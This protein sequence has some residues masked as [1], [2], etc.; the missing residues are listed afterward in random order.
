MVFLGLGGLIL[1]RL[2]LQFVLLKQI[3]SPSAI[4]I[5]AVGLTIAAAVTL[6][7]SQWKNFI[8]GGVLA[9]VSLLALAI[10]C[11]IPAASGRAVSV[12]R[13]PGQSI[14]PPPSMA[15]QPAPA[16]QTVTI[17][18]IQTAQGFP[19][20]ARG[21]KLIPSTNSIKVAPPLEVNTPEWYGLAHTEKIGGTGGVAYTFLD[22][23]RRPIIGLRYETKEWIGSTAIGQLIPVY[24]R[25]MAKPPAGMQPLSQFT[26]KNGYVVAGLVID[27]DTVV[28][29]VQPICMRWDGGRLDPNDQYQA[30][31]IGNSGKDAPQTLGGD[32]KSVLG[33][34]GGKGIVLD[35]VGLV[36]APQ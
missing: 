22:G 16:L 18:A 36:L 29:G 13:T 32:A 33:I 8:A 23:G 2:G 28:R 24:D 15:T 31:W 5:A 26:A 12:Q 9:G 11:V 27:A 35:S 7:F 20:T 34:F 17:A 30:D 4:R 1:P 21:P 25:V 6:F 14:V 19:G 3:G 10:I